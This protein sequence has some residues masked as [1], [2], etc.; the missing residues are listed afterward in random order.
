[1]TPS[2]IT[3][4]TIIGGGYVGLVSATAF[5]SFGSIVT[6]IEQDPYRLNALIKGE[7]PFYEPGL[8]ELF[9]EQQKAGRLIIS[10]NLAQAL[11]HAQAAFIAVGTPTQ[12]DSDQT[13]L[14]FVYQ[15]TRS[16]ALSAS[17][18]LIIVTKSTVPVGT[19]RKILDICKTLRPQYQFHIVSN[20]EFLRQ[21][22]ALKDFIN[23]DRV[24]IGI[25]QEKPENYGLVYDFMNKIYAPIPK[26]KRIFMGLESAELTKY[27]AN[28]FLAMKVAFINEIATL[29]EATHANISEVSHAIGL[30]PRI[31]PHCLSPGPGFGGSCFPKDTLALT[32]T[33]RAH[34]MTLPQIEASITANHNHQKRLTKRILTYKTPTKSQ[35]KIAVLGLAFKAKTDDMRASPALTILPPLHQAGF[36]LHL[37]DPYAMD[38]A[39]ALLPSNIAYA[40]TLPDAL[41]NADILLLLTEWDEFRAL[42]P[43]IIK[44]Y[45][46][47]QVIFDYRNLWN[48]NTFTKEG[49]DYH[50]LGNAS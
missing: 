11:S 31:N 44:K 37:Y 3:H 33:A 47:G 49:F 5:A 10:N 6:I 8:Q 30:D 38:N 48:K 4:L 16:I 18:D 29:C 24:V 7:I 14:S 36:H 25:N 23:P 43:K 27:A 32:I 41:Y 42:S 19:G 12:H 28:S 17:H 46:K 9:Q 26:E 39:R 2:S 50:N 21:G 45:M 40:S 13:D 15:A 22:N 35:Q 20:P 1:M 34:N